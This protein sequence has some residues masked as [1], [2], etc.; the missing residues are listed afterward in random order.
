MVGTLGHHSTVPVE[1]AMHVHA[2][3]RVMH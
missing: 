1:A 3:L 2:S